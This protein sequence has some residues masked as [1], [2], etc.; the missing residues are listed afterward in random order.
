M[1]VKDGTTVLPDHPVMK[2][3]MKVAERIWKEN[4]REEGITVTAGKD[5]VHSAG[6]WHYYGAA[7]DLRTKYWDATQATL[8]C[9]QLKGVL[10]AYDVVYHDSHIHVEPGDDLARKWGLLK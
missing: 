6:S 3:A 4:G 9:D 10:P 7:V 1:R 8:V 2:K 5:G